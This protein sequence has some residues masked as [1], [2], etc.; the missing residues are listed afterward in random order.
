[1]VGD[2]ERQASSLAALL[3]GT[4]FITLQRKAAPCESLAVLWLT[5]GR[6]YVGEVLSSG[7][8][9]HGGLR[10]KSSAEGFRMSRVA[11]SPKAFMF[12]PRCS[13]DFPQAVAR[14]RAQSHLDAQMAQF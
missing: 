2:A 11:A 5:R 14:G 3:G 8:G 7:M 13:G 6:S 10:R 4:A 1:M 12:M 9:A